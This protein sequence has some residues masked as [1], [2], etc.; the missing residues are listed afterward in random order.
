MGAQLK[1]KAA[2]TS[3]ERSAKRRRRNAEL[4]QSLEC[5]CVDVQNAQTLDEARSIAEAAVQECAA[6]SNRSVCVR[7]LSDP[8]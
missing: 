8:H 6:T 3:T 2:M 1:G 5:A 4:L 7:S